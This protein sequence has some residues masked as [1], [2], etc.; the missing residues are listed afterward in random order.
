MTN[1]KLKTYK[2]EGMDCASCA[3][4]LEMD[5]ED[6]GIKAS[7]SYPKSTLEVNGDHDT[8]KIIEIVK[9]SGFNISKI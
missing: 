1:D 2:I 4:L 7:C 8:K 9:K 3:S 6:I 5:L